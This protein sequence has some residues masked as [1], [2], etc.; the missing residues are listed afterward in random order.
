MKQ[1]VCASLI[2]IFF[3][4][5]LILGY[6]LGLGARNIETS[7]VSF[8]NKHLTASH[9]GEFK[10]FV[11]EPPEGSKITHYSSVTPTETPFAFSTMSQDSSMVKDIYYEGKDMWI[12][13]GFD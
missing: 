7:E 11:G 5:G 13:V 12:H 6:H 3:A 2:V 1:Y 8:G 4:F 10:E 9:K